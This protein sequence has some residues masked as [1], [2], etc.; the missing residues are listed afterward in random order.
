MEPDRN[1]NYGGFQM[2]VIRRQEAIERKKQFPSGEDSR[3]YY[4]PPRDPFEAIETSMPPGVRQNPHAHEILREATLV[5]EGTVVVGEI[6][7]GL[8]TEVELYPGDFV[9]FDPQSCHIMENRSKNP[10]RTLTFKFLGESKDAELFATDKI[11]HC[12]SPVKPKK[13][14]RNDS[15]FDSYV[16][17]YNNIDN[18]IWQIPAFLATVSAIGFAFLGNFFANPSAA[19]MPL[20]HNESVGAILILWSLFYFVGVY[21]I[22]RIRVHHTIAGNELAKL[23]SDGYF[24]QRE[25]TIKKLWPL[26]APYV[27]M[28]TFSALAI[29]L[30]AFGIYNLRL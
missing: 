23:E 2:Q 20:S 28:L 15:R 5:M 10:A 25:I 17:L 1:N 14:E 27:F 3:R 24:K 13:T 18:L 29:V 30:L 26:P 11:E 12:T 16:K 21:S 6:V 4:L 7:N 19:L 22:W 8:P 9:I